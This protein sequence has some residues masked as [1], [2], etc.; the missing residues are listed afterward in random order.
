MRLWTGM[1]LL[2][3]TAP[4]SGQVYRSVGPDGTVQFSDQPAEGATPGDVQPAQTVPMGG[5][6]L[7]SPAPAAPKEAAGP[8]YNRFEIL[9]PAPDE[10]VR[11]NDGNVT[12]SLALDPPL[13]PGHR[14]VVL[15]DGRP[16]GSPDAS[17]QVALTNLDRGTHRVE[18]SV[19]N[20]G[21]QTLAS[22]GPL[23]FHVLRVH[24]PPQRPKPK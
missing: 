24:L 1:L 21:G 12:V 2:F 23:T 13:L 6:T 3:L 17:L 22:A 19:V 8:A 11:A 7:R 9:S 15:V 10:G 4:A 14:V 16:V 18:A 5:P 20:A